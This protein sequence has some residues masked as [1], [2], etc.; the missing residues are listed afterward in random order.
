MVGVLEC[1]SSW[2]IHVHITDRALTFDTV[3]GF[4]SH[5]LQAA[6]KT[7]QPASHWL[8]TYCIYI[9]IYV[10]VIGS[11]YGI[12]THIWRISMVSVGKLYHTWTLWVYLVLREVDWQ[13][14][15][16]LCSA[17]SLGKWSNSRSIFFQLDWFSH[18]LDNTFAPEEMA[19]GILSIWGPVK[20]S[21]FKSFNDRK[22][23]RNDWFNHPLVEVT[24]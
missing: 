8:N 17:R 23:G 22:V 4:D 1:W 3:L 24:F 10:Y 2:E 16:F 6:Q 18:Q 20:N 13:L 15:Y 5:I 19:V 11:M 21:R 9:Y 7:C 12:F 14:N